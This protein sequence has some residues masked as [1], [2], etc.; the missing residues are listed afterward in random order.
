MATGSPGETKPEHQKGYVSCGS[1]GYVVAAP[2]PLS[3]VNNNNNIYIYL[4]GFKK[5]PLYKY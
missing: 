5:T 2:I 1:G 3:L 4:F